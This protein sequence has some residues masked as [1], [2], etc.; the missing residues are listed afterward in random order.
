MWKWL[1]WVLL[2]LGVLVVCFIALIA[3]SQNW[4]IVDIDPTKVPQFIQADFID[5]TKVSNVSKF[6][7][8][9]GHD[10]SDSVEHCSSMRHYFGFIDAPEI[11]AEEGKDIALEKAKFLIDTFSPVDGR[12]MG[13]SGDLAKHGQQINI[14]PDNYPSI[15]VRI[16]NLN[17][18][19][20]IH[21]L[22][23]LKAGQK[24]GESRGM[25]EIT[26][27]YNFPFGNRYNLSYFTLMPDSLFAKYQKAARWNITKDDFIITKEY[28][29]VHPLECDKVDTEKFIPSAETNTDYNY[30]FLNGF[31]PIRSEDKKVTK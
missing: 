19:P 12:V 18:D 5:V 30:V 20:S 14:K 23:K 16:D 9:V 25:A 10:A 11:Q 7:S 15:Q 29:N 22:S 2:T 13:I 27:S 6:R 4:H 17:V 21:A 26:I 3:W 8:G 28:R 24:I 31:S 1:R